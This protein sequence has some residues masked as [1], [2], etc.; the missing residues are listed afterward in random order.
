MI[1]LLFLSGGS[2]VGQNILEALKHRR[3]GL[4]LL[5]VNSIAEEPAIFEYD[6]VLLAPS[7]VE[8][9]DQFL[10]FFNHLM[11]TQAIDLV[12]PCRDEDVA[13]LSKYYDS[14]ESLRPK[15]LCGPSAVAIPLLDKALSMDFSKNVHLP[16]APTVLANAPAEEVQDF[17]DTHGYPILA[18]PKKGFASRGV[19]VLTNERQVS[20]LL[21]RSDYI[22]QKYLSNPES[23]SNYLTLLETEGVPLFHTFEEVK[24]SVQASIGPDG[25]I[26]GILVTEHVMKQGKSERIARCKDPQ[27]QVLAENWVTNIVESGWRGPLNIQSQ[28]SHNGEIY[29]YEFN[30]RFTGATAGRVAMG[31]DEVGIILKMWLGDFPLIASAQQ[32]DFISRASVSK[33]LDQ[34]KVQKL[35]VDKRWK[36]V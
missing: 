22:F 31:F 6:E 8:N 32:H 5:A 20:S 34:Q 21:G 16:F 12:I 19:R 23:V 24:L 9:P 27:M 4:Y 35:T 3:E 1:H 13:F 30:G 7:L 11:D 25:Q 18:K 33:V 29:I 26:G 10:D 17:I 15:L 28:K 2:L 14:H 36:K